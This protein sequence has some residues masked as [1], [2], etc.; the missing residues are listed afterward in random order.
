[1]KRIGEKF[2]KKVNSA[3]EQGVNL[4]NQSRKGESERW[5]ESFALDSN[6]KTPKITKKVLGSNNLRLGIAGTSEKTRKIVKFKNIFWSKIGSFYT[7]KTV[8]TLKFAELGAFLDK[9][10][11]FSF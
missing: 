4:Q 9:I 3:P 8:R 7:R 5:A 11:V 2:A 1:M 10:N 6:Q